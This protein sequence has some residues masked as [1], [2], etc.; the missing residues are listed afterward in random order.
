MASA[1]S[2]PTDEDMITLAEKF[3]LEGND[4][5]KNKNVKKAM[6]KYH[7]AILQLKGVGSDEKMSAVMGI[8]G[9][10]TKKLSLEL[11]Q[12]FNKL[13]TDCYNNLA[14]MKKKFLLLRVS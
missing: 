2:R 11:E 3:K 6:G 9:P 1:T 8:D 7:R 5:F 4:L 10:P 12:K 13:K 14:G